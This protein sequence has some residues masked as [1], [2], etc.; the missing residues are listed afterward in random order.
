MVRAT[1]VTV[2]IRMGGT[3]WVN[4][5]ATNV[6]NLCIAADYFLDAYTH[7]DTLSTTGNN[8]IAIATSIVMNMIL[9]NDWFAAGGYTCGQPRPVVMTE[10]IVTRLNI[11]KEST[12]GDDDTVDMIA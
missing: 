10:D 6:G 5:D 4:Y 9:V 8:E 12:A 11:L 3:Y 2:L 7:P 1:T